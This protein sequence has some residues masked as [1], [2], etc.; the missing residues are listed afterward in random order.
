MPVQQELEAIF[1]EIDRAP[2]RQ[3]RE[4]LVLQVA[5]LLVAG[6]A[7]FAEEHVALF[8]M[9]LERLVDRIEFDTRVALAERIAGLDRGPIRLLERLAFDEQTAVAGPVLARSPRL[10]EASLVKRATT[11]ASGHLLA[12]AGRSVVTEPVTDVL[13]DRGDPPVHVRVAGNSGARLSPDG[14]FQLVSKAAGNDDL[15]IILGGRSDLTQNLLLRLISS[16]SA[17][18]RAKLEAANEHRR[19]D[20]HAVLSEVTRR[21]EREVIQPPRDYGAARGEIDKLHAM[22]ALRDVQIRAFAERGR[23]EHLTVALSLLAGIPAEAVAS[24]LRQERVEGIMIIARAIDLTWQ[25]TREILRMKA[26]PRGLASQALETAAFGFERLKPETAKLA[27]QLQRRKL[28]SAP[29]G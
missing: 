9:L 7:G 24:A 21:V 6:A 8:D 26:G 4:G 15:T 3:R 28:T 13:I 18:A 5:D 1:R 14:Y 29:R 27:L 19:S 17:V 20:I 22:G 16:A 2:T 12:I 23:V 25:T 11:G 10:T